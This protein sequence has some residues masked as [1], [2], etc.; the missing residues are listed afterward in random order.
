VNRDGCFAEYLS[1]PATNAWHVHDDISSDIAAFFD[2][3]GNATHSALSFNMVGEDVLITGAGPIGI[4]C[5]AIAKH[6]GARHVVI[7]DVIDERLALA[8]TLGATRTVNVMNESLSEVKHELGMREGFDVGLEMSGNPQALSDQITHMCHGGKIAILGI[9]AQNT[10]IDWSQVIFNML[11]LKGIYGREMY[12]TWYKMSV[13]IQTGLDISP[14]ITHRM[15][16]SDF[17]EGFTAMN[18]G[19]ASK[20]ILS[21]DD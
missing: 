11:T 5:V 20:V 7:T 1:F 21:W 14:V 9:P 6:V 18:N 16:Y 2:P 3:Y 4:M 12:E 8:A 10:A 15:H 17:D 19:S 13:M